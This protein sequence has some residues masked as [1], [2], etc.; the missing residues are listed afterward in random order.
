MLSIVSRETI[1][2]YVEMCKP[3]VV[4]LMLLSAVVGISLA[5]PSNKAAWAAALWGL[6]GI[7]LMASSGAVVNHVLDV[8]YD[9]KMARTQR[10]PLPKQQVTSTQALGFA[11]GL[12][13]LGL[14]VLWGLVNP[15]TFYLTSAA[16]LGYAIVY[17]RYLKHATPQN[18]V[19]GGLS[20]ALP[21]LLG[22]VAVTHHIDIQPLLLVLIIFTWTPVHF[23]A[24]AIHRHED[25]AL[26]DIPMLPVTHGLAYTKLC[27]ILYTVLTV[28]A[29]ILP[30]LLAVCGLIY[31]LG[32]LLLNA[33]LVYWSLRLRASEDLAIAMRAFRYSITYLMWLFVFMVVDH[34][35]LLL[36]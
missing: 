17:T 26:A 25:Y 3:K 18:I 19:I 7:G 11:L 6:L 8:K 31:L 20:G 22:W 33:G 2:P 35:W 23:W 30:C 9:E 10:R 5:N 1:W 28:L 24:L 16:T 12:A 15:L 13:A 27:I 21:P 36:V 34:Q 29:S 32:A 4:A 14:L